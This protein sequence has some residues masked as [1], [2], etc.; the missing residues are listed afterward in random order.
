MQ[1]LKYLWYSVNDKSKIP[2]VAASDRHRFD[3]GIEVGNLAKKLYPT[4]I[5]IASEDIGENLRKTKEM[6]LL[7]KPLFE[8]A[9]NV[10]NLYARAD[11]LVPH[12]DS[13]DIIEVKSSTSV[14]DEHIQDVSFQ[15][16]VFE[17]KGLK[18]K[19]CYVMYVNNEYVRS[20]EI[21]VHKFFKKEEIE[22]SSDISDKLSEMFK[23][24]DSKNIPNIPIGK[25]CFSPY[26]CPLEYIC[27][28]DVPA[29]S[30][31]DL[32]RVSWKLFDKGV[33]ELN[34][35]PND[36]KLSAG[37][38]IQMKALLS[39]KIYIDK[40]GITQFIDRLKEPVHYF[41]FETHSGAI[42]LYDGMKPYQR[43]P[44]QYS[45]H[46]END[47]KS[48]LDLSGKDPREKLILQLKK[49]VKDKGTILAYNMSFEIGVLE[50]IAQAFPKH[51]KWIEEFISR[52]VDLITP[53]RNYS[54]YNPM[55]GSSNSL[56]AVLPAVTGF[57]YSALKINNGADA[58]LAY[59]SVVKGI[60]KEKDVRVDLEKYCG[61]DTEGMVWI[62]EKLREITK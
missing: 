10:D 37:N 9:V 35:V 28:K 27:W 3:E 2:E 34:D 60:I 7:K 8:A 47:H 52:V 20:G 17:K 38:K 42:P 11:I 50:E 5:D 23:A 49:D 39:G 55:Q 59:I 30:V 24:I 33:I 18:I 48:F 43:I 45:L 31:F 41:D 36:F 46:V 6:L 29:P 58:S 14:K 21:D 13:W 56:K 51:K 53:F 32:S 57:D 54:Y 19:K 22:P 40:I 26:D 12:D 62:V 25:Y 44:F 1:C 16:Y 4:G 61:L 15:K